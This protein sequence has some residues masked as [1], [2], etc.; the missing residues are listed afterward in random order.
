MAATMTL[1]NSASAS[2]R[3][4]SSVVSGSPNSGAELIR[5]VTKR[6]A[7]TC[8]RRVRMS[9]LVYLGGAGNRIGAAAMVRTQ[10]RVRSMPELTAVARPAGRFGTV[11]LVAVEFAALAGGA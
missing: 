11:Q 10:R 8:S 1:P 7:W 4:G 5:R 3:I 6:Y 9:A 2:R